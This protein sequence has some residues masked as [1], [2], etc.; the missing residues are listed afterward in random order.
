VPFER[1]T[2]FIRTASLIRPNGTSY[3]R[4]ARFV[5]P[6]VVRGP[7]RTRTRIITPYFSS[8]RPVNARSPATGQIPD[9]QG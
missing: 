2:W 8:E 6:N 9:S 1:Q 5:R 7:Y 3:V 4:T